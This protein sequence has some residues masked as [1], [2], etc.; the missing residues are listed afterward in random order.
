MGKGDIYQETYDDIVQLCIRCSHGI[1]KTISEI[2]APIT[3]SSN[4][5]SEGVTRLKVGNILE[6]FKTYI[7]STLTKKLDVLLVK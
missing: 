7:L 4:F 5:T 1:T 6:N 3:R 2:R